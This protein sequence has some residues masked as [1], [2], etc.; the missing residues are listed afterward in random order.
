[1]TENVPIIKHK[2]NL[3]QSL[4]FCNNVQLSVRNYKTRKPSERGKKLSLLTSEKVVTKPDPG[5][6]EIVGLSDRG[7]KNHD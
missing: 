1:M 7:F 2:D 4:F 6:T 3:L 5:M